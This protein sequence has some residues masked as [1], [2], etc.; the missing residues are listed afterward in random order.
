[1]VG[2]KTITKHWPSVGGGWGFRWYF[3]AGLVVFGIWGT[4][5]LC[6]LLQIGAIAGGLLEFMDLAFGAHFCGSFSEYG[7]NHW[8]F[9]KAATS[10]ALLILQ[11]KREC[12]MQLPSP[13]VCTPP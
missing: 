9:V 8:F 10:W 11:R 6:Y 2:A 12:L 7:V 13:G 3:K 4:I 1:M 5:L